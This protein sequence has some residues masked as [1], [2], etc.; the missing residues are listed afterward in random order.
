[1]ANTSRI[2]G[3]KPV[4]HLSGAPYNGQANLYYMASGYATAAYVG[5]VVKIVT[6]ADTTGRAQTVELAAAGNAVVGVIVGFLP[7][8]TNLD[9][10][11]TYRAASTARY[12]WVADSPDTIFQ[13][14]ASNG[15]PVYSDLGLNVNHAVGTPN[16]TFARSGAYLDW[17]TEANTATLTFKVLSIVDSPDNEIGAS[18]K[19]LVKINNHQLGSHTG[20]V[21]L[22]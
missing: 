4:K 8:P 15:T 3:F 19:L 14:E 16:A 18:V 22:P 9:V 17:G 13:A 20:T 5:D 7:E 6:A 12:C 11:G 1:M 21:G 2:N 10:S